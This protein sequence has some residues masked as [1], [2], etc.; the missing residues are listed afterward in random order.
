MSQENGRLYIVTQDFLDE[1]YA[2]DA[3]TKYAR[4]LARSIFSGTQPLEELRKLSGLT[5]AEFARV[6]SLAP[7]RDEWRQLERAKRAAAEAGNPTTP[8]KQ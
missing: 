1:K 8:G 3:L 2:T 4:P 5:S 6:R 7:Y